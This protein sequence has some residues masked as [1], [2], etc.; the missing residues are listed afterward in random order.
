MFRTLLEKELKNV[1]FGPKFPGTF[2]ICSLLILV[3]IIIGIQDYKASVRSYDAAIRLED[4]VLSERY[5]WRSLGT[6]VYRKP[7]P[8]HI[9]VSGV[10][11]DIGRFS[12]VSEMES[13]RLQRSHY[14]EDPIFAV[15]RF[16]DLSFIYQVVLSLFAVLFTFN[17]VNGERE[18]GTLQL[19]FSNAVSRTQ[20]IAAKYIGSWLGLVVPLL[21]PVLAG[22]LVVIASGVPVTGNHW[23]AIGAFIG[24]STLYFSFFIALGIFVSACTRHSAVSFL[25][26]LMVWVFFVLIIPRLG[27]MTAGRMIPVP[28]IAEIDG[29]IDAFSDERWDS[30]MEYLNDV[31]RQ[32]NTITEGMSEAERQAY[33]DE[34]L[35]DW[36]EETDKARKAV[37][38]DIAAF[39]KTVEDE[40]R[41]KKAA[42]EELAFLLARFSPVSSYQLASMQLAGTHSGMKETYER[43]IARYKEEFL[44]YS[45]KK[46]EESGNDR[47]GFSISVSS[48]GLSFSSGQPENTIDTADVPRFSSAAIHISDVF[49]AAL[50]D[51]IILLLLTAV[52]LSGGFFVFLRYDVRT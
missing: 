31:F 8:M 26:L 36:T 42:Q 34:H 50:S 1:L 52:M 5:S 43:E 23:A 15:F 7:D 28:S 30:Y 45:A 6:R 22:M 3:S 38:T 27:M 21:I 44:A 10:T 32:R 46:A 11:H 17:A 40:L 14:S 12:P 35:W 25:G 24:V 16:F 41:L 37:Q 51:F 19:I 13:V 29:R 2:I 18:Q 33:R 49:R 39:T 9:F 20:Y 48:G 47:A 4:Q